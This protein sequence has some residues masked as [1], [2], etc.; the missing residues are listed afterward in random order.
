MGVGFMDRFLYLV[1]TGVLVLSLSCSSEKPGNIE[2]KSGEETLRAGDILVG[3]MIIASHQLDSNEINEKGL[4]V[5]LVRLWEDG[6]LPYTFAPDVSVLNRQL[7]RQSC[8]EMGKFANVECVPRRPEDKDYIHVLNATENICGLSNLGRMGGRQNLKIKCWN[9]RTVQHE[10]MH[11]FGISHEHNR[12]DRDNYITI[13]WDN[14]DP[15]LKSDLYKVNNFA[16]NIQS[17][18]YDFNSIMHYGSFSGSKNGR[19]VLYKKD[20]GPQAG[21]ITPSTIM[22]YYDHSILYNLYG[23]EK[24]H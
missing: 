3:D 5:K 22:S 1:A 24:P 9:K 11:A 12:T 21:Q 17:N 2:V 16:V 20:K 4:N 18:V 6:V 19:I 23:G 7:F 14:L 8:L 10:L 15:G 13:E